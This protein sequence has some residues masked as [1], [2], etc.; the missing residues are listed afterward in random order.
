MREQILH[1]CEIATGHRTHERRAARLRLQQRS[2]RVDPLRL[3][4][5]QLG[6]RPLAATASNEGKRSAAVSTA[7][8]GV[9]AGIEQDGHKVAGGRTAGDVK[10]SLS[11]P[12]TRE[13]LY[14]SPG[15]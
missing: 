8:S 10:R 11:L 15:L 9:G 1:T 5:I 14:I 12:V 3:C 13:R 4:G 2:A 7:G 6:S